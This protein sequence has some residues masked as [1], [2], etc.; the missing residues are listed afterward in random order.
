M[1]P[2]EPKFKLPE[3]NTK[4]STYTPRFTSTLTGGLFRQST[5]P[6]L[7][8]EQKRDL[9]GRPIQPQAAPTET[10]ARIAALQKQVDNLTKRLTESEGEKGDG[11]N[12]FEKMVNL[13]AGQVW[14]MDAFD[15]IDR[16]V[17]AIKEG[18]SDQSVATAWEAFKGNRPGPFE[19]GY[20]EGSQFLVNI[21]VIP[22]ATLRNASAEQKLILDIGV[23]IFADPLTYTGP[24]RI[25][26][27]LGILSDSK[28]VSKLD[29]VIV[30]ARKAGLIELTD[31]AI[32]AAA[33]KGTDDA[34]EVLVRGGMSR[35]AAVELVKKPL[36]EWGTVA[37]KAYD[38]ALE[39]AGIYNNKQFKDILTELNQAIDPV[40]GRIINTKTVGKTTRKLSRIIDRISKRIKNVLGGFGDDLVEAAAKGGDEAL[41]ALD[42]ALVRIDL[43]RAPLLGQRGRTAAQTRRFQDLTEARKYL[44]K[45]RKSMTK[46]LSDEGVQT[47]ADLLKKLPGEE[48]EILAAKKLREL[49]QSKL[50][51]DLS[52]N[53]F[54]VQRKVKDTGVDLEIYLR[55]V[56]ENGTE[57]FVKLQGRNGKPFVFEVKNGKRFALTPHSLTPVNYDYINGLKDRINT[58]KQKATKTASEV[59]KLAD[60]Q[61]EVLE[62]ETI[63]RQ[64]EGVPGFIINRTKRKEII[65]RIGQEQYNK[66]ERQ[67]QKIIRDGVDNGYTISQ[68]FDKLQE[69]YR[70]VDD[71]DAAKNYAKGSNG[72]LTAAA[73]KQRNKDILQLR[74]RIYADFRIE[75]TRRFKMTPNIYEKGTLGEDYAKELLGLLEEGT[76]D[77]YGVIVKNA[78]GVEELVILSPDEFF[79]KIKFKNIMISNT[80]R[81][82]GAKQSFFRAYYGLDVPELQLD[83]FVKRNDWLPREFETVEAVTE[84]VLKQEKVIKEGIAVKMLNYVER[85]GIPL[86]S[87]TVGLIKKGVEAL[88]FLFDAKAGLTDELA[89][90]LSKVPAEDIQAARVSVAKVDSITNDI[91]A[92]TKGRYD[93]KFVKETI[94]LLIE[95][96]WDGSA[97]LLRKMTLEN[98]WLRWTQQYA[99][100]GRSQFAAMDAQKFTDFVEQWKRILRQEGYSDDF[101]K[102]TQKNVGQTNAYTA[103]EFAEG[104]T[105]KELEEFGKNLSAVNRDVVFDLGKGNL[106]SEQLALAKEFN[107]Q[108]QQIIEETL[109]QRELLRQLGFEFKE[110]MLGTGS[111]FRHAINPKML[112]Y[113]KK[114]SQAASIKQFLDAGTDLLKERLYIGSVAE[115]N[116]AVRDMFGINIDLFSTDVTYNFAD[117]VRVA[118]TK[119][120]MSQVLGAML[121]QQDVI[122]RSLFEIVSEQDIIARGLKGQF[123][124]L[125]GSFKAEFPNLF[126]NISPQTQ[127]MLLKYFADSGLGEAG[128]AI[129]IQKSAY[130]VLKRLDNAYVQLPEFVKTFDQYMKFWKT[131][132]LITPGYHMRNFF[133]NITNSFMVGM[134]LPA[135]AQYMFRSSW[136]FTRYKRVM[137][138]LERGE[139]I[140]GLNQSVLDAF[141]RVDQYYRSGASQSH[142]GVRD[143]EI[144]KEGMRQIKGQRRGP[145]RKLGDA[146][147]NINY[148]AAEAMDDYQRYSLYLW[149]FDT[150]DNSKA[151]RSAID[152]GASKNQIEMLKR[153]EAYK[154][155]SEALFDYSHLTAFEKEYMKRLFPFYTFFKNNLILQAKTIFERPGQYAKLFRS[156]RYY[157]ESMTGMDVED[158]PNYMTDNLWLPMPFQ[159]KKDD[160]EAIAWLRANLPPSDF[161]EF[162]ENPF[163]RGVVSLTAPIKMFIELGT[164]RD[165]FTG[166]QIREFP[167]QKNEYQGEGFLS[168]MRDQ[169]GRFTLSTD[170]YIAKF[171]NDI[172]FRSIFSYGTSAIDI[173]DYTQGTQTRGNMIQAVLDSLGITRVQELDKIEIASLYQNLDKLRDAKDLYEQENEGKLPSLEDLQKIANEQDPTGGVFDNLFN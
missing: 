132:A 138:M 153:R 83:E 15:L 58:L 31:D 35:E 21:G 79:K 98:T 130:G 65:R 23:D 29:D 95:Q 52:D 77:A 38:D 44:I 100:A 3:F 122:G 156:Y 141:Q 101:I 37:R 127:E 2:N 74:D 105:V 161:T 148:S 43:E 13:P 131:F 54:V 126:K 90:F 116:A 60:L 165:L 113:L 47:F 168:S 67:F 108:V 162:V 56:D 140:T 103:V 70:A 93:P 173:Y 40:T 133:G 64:S 152:V 1:Q 9:F 170:P 82:S 25:L 75:G 26:K 46:M 159:V 88:S 171:L 121:K 36:N 81:S 97:T 154:K 16:P 6:S 104:T 106:T 8:T 119:N 39:A 4:Q 172:G 18:L 144:I 147:L 28:I 92:A 155:V 17:R 61:E 20:L 91:V 59:E 5:Q 151:V 34:I 71:L 142:R 78:Q 55:K 73:R 19:E 22:E 99:R 94:N 125:G 164:G 12:W 14:W 62:L 72:K 114:N 24:I 66:L 96:G 42:D 167:G 84:K 41:Q 146:I 68:Y 51:R 80:A 129:A 69:F 109:S 7:P 48:A 10:E 124:I 50:D 33:K 11:R 163:Q 134:S 150:A 123:N 169:K 157:T 145:V 32:K 115:I 128:R 86:V 166:Q 118:T 135:Q 45:Q 120:E 149:A 27:Q 110:G 143:L 76:K 117:L 137:R 49:M 85:A 112:A 111:Y 53:I 63:L 139:D 87:P 30:Q 102:F 107:P 160:K 57:T 89:E 158:L 136:D